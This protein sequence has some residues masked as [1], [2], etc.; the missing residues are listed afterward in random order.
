MNWEKSILVVLLFVGAVWGSATIFYKKGYNDSNLEWQTNTVK[1]G[2]AHYN[3]FSGM[4]E[5]NPNTKE[6][7]LTNVTTVIEESSDSH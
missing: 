7:I 1:M 5:W 2:Y 3:T 6:L 4:W